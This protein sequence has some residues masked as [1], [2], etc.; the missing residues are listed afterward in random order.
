[1]HTENESDYCSN[2]CDSES[3][4]CAVSSYFSRG[5]R[6]IFQPRTENFGV[7]VKGSTVEFHIRGEKAENESKI[8]QKSRHSVYF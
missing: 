2:E 4:L 6:I 7:E 3:L 1:M 5:Y 8:R